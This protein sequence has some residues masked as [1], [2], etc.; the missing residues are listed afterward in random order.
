MLEIYENKLLGE[1]YYKT[2]HKSGLT[3]YVYP[4]TRSTAF[5]MLTTRYGSLEREFSLEGDAGTITVPDGVAHFLEHKL[6][7]EEDGSDAFEKFAPL[8]ASANAF[9][10]FD[11]TSYLFSTTDKLTEALEVLLSF[12]THPHFTEENVKKEQGIIAQEIGMCDDDPW[13]RLYYSFLEGLYRD[14]N[15]RINI[16]GTVKTISEITPEILYRC[17]HT[18]YQLSNMALVVSGDITQ[19]EVMET[20]DRVLPTEATPRKITCHYPKESAAV[21]NPYTE[22]HMAIAQPLFAFGVKDVTEFVSPTEKMR[23]AL[24]MEAL[25]KACLSRSSAFYN[26]LYNEGLL[27]KDIGFSFESPN[28]C[29]Y[30]I[31]TGESDQPIEIFNRTKHLLQNMSQNLPSEEDFLRIKRAMYAN[32]VRTFDST[33]SLAMALTDNF[34]NGTDLM[35]EGELI[36]NMTYEEFAKFASAY[37]TDKEFALSVIYPTDE[38]S[39]ENE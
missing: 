20:V 7:E 37:F 8:G 31:I 24:M 11:M 38:E 4:K 36:A 18:F 17:Y 35:T 29:A 15:V 5:V 1:K 33:E 19:S 26:S 6:F 22:L 3:V 32:Y 39:E 30:F 13:N 12:T 9:T 10:S 25:G 27:T 14:H 23:R 21:K 34:V 2:V 16:A 28:S